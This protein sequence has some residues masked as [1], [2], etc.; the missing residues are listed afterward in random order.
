MEQNLSFAEALEI[1]RALNP[2][3]VTNIKNSN[4][5]INAISKQALNQLKAKNDLTITDNMIETGSFTNYSLKHDSSSIPSPLV[6]EIADDSTDLNN[7]IP[8]IVKALQCV[9]LRLDRC[10]PETINLCKSKDEPEEPLPDL[11]HSGDLPPGGHNPRL[12]DCTHRIEKKCQLGA[13]G[14]LNG[15]LNPG[16]PC[17]YNDRHCDLNKCPEFNESKEFNTDCLAEILNRVGIWVGYECVSREDKICQTGAKNTIR[18]DIK[19]GEE[20]PYGKCTVYSCPDFKL[21]KE[22]YTECLSTFQ[23]YIVWG[24]ICFNRDKE[25]IRCASGANNTVKGDVKP[26]DICPFGNCYQTYCSSFDVGFPF[27]WCVIP[28]KMQRNTK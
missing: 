16:D 8:V 15:D 23:G 22:V 27:G 19:V 5:H 14:T 6:S 3:K 2:L 11:H 4:I 28:S 25:G 10:C 26:G 20:C 18:G 7:I 17:A 24:H 12:Y 21:S 9:I 1:I 13:K